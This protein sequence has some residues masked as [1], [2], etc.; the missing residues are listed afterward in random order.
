MRRRENTRQ[1]KT[2]G[3][4]SSPTQFRNGERDRI[5]LACEKVW[6]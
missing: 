2:G 3:N 1:I 4:L 5:D 6:N